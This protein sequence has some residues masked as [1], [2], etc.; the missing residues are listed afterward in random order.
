[1]SHE[2]RTPMN[3]IMGMIHLC[4]DTALTHQ[5]QEY[6][7]KAYGAAKSLL[8]LLN[9]ILDL[10]K[11]EAG[12]L[13]I[14]SIPFTLYE[15]MEHLVT[16]VGHKAEEKGLAFKLDIAPEAP[17]ALV[18]DPLRLGQILINL[19]NNAVKFTHQ[20]EISIAVRRLDV[21]DTRVHLEF[22]VQDTGMGM[23]A[24]QSRIIFQPF[25]QAD[26]SITRKYG[27]TGLGLS[28]CKQLVEMMEG[29][30]HV[31][32][33][34]GEGSLFRFDVWLGVGERDE[35]LSGV[36]GADR[37]PSSIR[38]MQIDRLAG[39]RLLVV[40]DNDIN[41]EI[42][43]HLLERS[44]AIVEIAINGAQAVAL[45]ERQGP[46]A[47]NAVLMD[48]Q[49]P[50]MDGY[51]A[52]RRIRALPGFD[53]LPII[54]LTAH[55]QRHEIERMQAVGMNDHV[56]KPI[57]PRLLLRILDHCLIS[58]APSI[59]EEQAAAVFPGLSGTEQSVAGSLPALPGIDV[60]ACLD[61]LNGDAVLLRQLFVNFSDHYRQTA[62]NLRGLL[63]AGSRTDAVRLAHSVKGVAGNLG[64]VDV[65]RVATQLESALSRAE[66]GEIAQIDALEKA[67]QSVCNV[68]DSGLD[69]LAVQEKFD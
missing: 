47:F 10:S 19:G 7:N 13:E 50:E 52:T 32:S 3:A 9:D 67:I 66:K 1:M 25:R 65:Q 59:V 21:R 58:T 30:L 35:R 2:I 27:G 68:I 51:E 22:A 15:V 8:G 34:P 23:T 42:I 63:A 62:Q 54:G 57:D 5:Q 38:I 14:A 11:V 40:E 64:M 28:I 55:V 17:D 45:L 39:R 48:I 24:E 36:N 49:M 6:L 33:R 18:G 61:R 20:G 16:I 29:T 37:D 60:A 4:L 12:Q 56:G 46:K 69:G 26:N 44:G 41:Q 43:R 53:P 31:D